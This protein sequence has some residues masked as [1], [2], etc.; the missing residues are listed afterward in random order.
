MEDNLRRDYTARK[1][2]YDPWKGFHG[3]MM[4]I[5]IAQLLGHDVLRAMARALG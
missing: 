1:M 5:P 3:F 2:D 4:Q